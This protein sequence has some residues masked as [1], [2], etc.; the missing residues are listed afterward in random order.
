MATFSPENMLNFN[1]VIYLQLKVNQLQLADF[2][3]VG[4][5]CILGYLAVYYSVNGLHTLF[6][7][8]V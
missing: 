8:C 7:C 1:K 5:K 3:S 2:G 6:V 4:A